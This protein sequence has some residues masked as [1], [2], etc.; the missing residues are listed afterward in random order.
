MFPHKYVPVD[1]AINE[2]LL[3][4][5]KGEKSGF[6]QVGDKK[7]LL[8]IAYKNHAEEYY[9]LPLRKDDIWV[10]TFPRSG[11]TLTQELVWIINN[12]LDFKTSLSVSLQDRF[13]FME[14]NTLIHDEHAQEIIDMNNDPVVTGLVKSW[15]TPGPRIAKDLKSPRHFKTHLPFSLLPP[16][17]LNTSKVIYVAR[18]PDDVVASYYYHNKLVRLHDYTNDFQQYWNYFKNDLVVFAPYW[19]HVE[20]GWNRRSHP[21]LLF[22][23][24][25]D[26]VKD[27]R[28]VIR[29]VASFL[30]KTLSEDNVDQVF[31]HLQIENLRKVP[32]LTNANLVGFVNGS[33]EGFIRQGKVG[34]NKELYGQLK[35]DVDEWVQ[36]NLRKTGLPP[37]PV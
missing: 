3:R 10:V 22:L 33:G 18:N 25:E 1:N 4:D 20:E 11:T 8:P 36:E 19:K 24:Y 16:N 37:F 34:G 21:N 27:M 12:D 28:S 23:Y 7:W 9:T 13:P 32:M 6:C 30:G 5:F 31:A 35:E 15:K 29:K 17:L 14:L 2:K 26:I